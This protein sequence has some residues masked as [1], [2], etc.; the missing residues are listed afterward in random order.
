MGVRLINRFRPKW[1]HPKPEVR[2]AAVEK[3]KDPAVLAEV[4]IYDENADV[5][6]AAIEKLDNELVLYVIA[7][8]DEFH[9]Y[10]GRAAVGKLV[11]QAMLTNIAMY[12]CDDDARKAAV[13]KIEDQ[14]ALAKLANHASGDVRVAA[15][16]KLT[17]PSLLTYF[18]RRGVWKQRRAAVRK[19]TDQRML[20]EIAEM[21]DN[22]DV[23]IAAVEKLTDPAALTEI[24]KT[25]DNFGVRVSAVEKLTDQAVLTEIAKTD[26][27][28]RVRMAA[29]E[30][31]TH[32][33]LLTEIANA[34]E[35]FRKNGRGLAAAPLAEHCVADGSAEQL[36]RLWRKGEPF[37]SAL[38]EA[39]TGG[40][41][42]SRSRK[43]DNSHQVADFLM[44]IQRV[45]ATPLLES[46]Q[47]PDAMK[48]VVRAWLD[49]DL[50]QLETLALDRR[51]LFEPIPLHWQWDRGSGEDRT[52]YFK[53]GLLVAGSSKPVQQGISKGIFLLEDGH[54]AILTGEKWGPS[55][56]HVWRGS[57]ST[58]AESSLS[59]E[60]V[61]EA[62]QCL[63]RILLKNFLERFRR[64]GHPA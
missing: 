21:D 52:P 7:K 36:D 40:L 60:E 57:I 13:E 32:P 27:N 39:I 19:L 37:V 10:V 20:T 17:D 23:R 31:V 56:G 16:E 1:K 4:A 28:L 33:A 38:V 47:C 29:V 34:V 42:Y 58:S 26:R 64:R 30:K 2:R 35:A 9:D 43:L 50:S 25:A 41:H 44:N 49:R 6:K 11:S 63:A 14:A 3:C 59:G 46:R 15:V 8:S 18:A 62:V 24:A 5:R 61:E 55:H 45:D 12:A 54:L 22:F 51:E 53:R 48:R